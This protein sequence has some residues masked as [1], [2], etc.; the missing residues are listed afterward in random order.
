MKFE[1]G[2]DDITGAVN[3]AQKAVS[4]KSNVPQLEGIE[5]TAGFNSIVIFGSDNEIGVE[6]TFAALVEQTGAAVVNAR[7]FSDIVRN[8]QGDSVTVET[9]DNTK[10]RISS[11]GAVFNIF[12]IQTDTFPKFPVFEQTRM[13]EIDRLTLKRMFTQTS[14]AISTDETRKALTGLLLESA[15]GELRAVAVDGFRIALRKQ[16]V[17][18][19]G[20]WF[21]M[22][23]PARTVN[24]LI[25][26]IPSDMGD[27]RLYGGDNQAVI[28]FDG[29]RVY[30]RIIEGEFF[31][32][33]YILPNEH[34]TQIIVNKQ[35]LQD[36]IERA[37]LIISSELIK[38]YPVRINVA[39]GYISV[40]SRSD[41]GNAD[42]EIDVEMEGEPIELAFNPRFLIETL[43]AVEDEKIIMRFTT[44]VGQCVIKRINN[45][46]YTY[47]ILP[48]KVSE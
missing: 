22:I 29:T 23:I 35:L 44:R 33:R 41:V 15:N 24:E 30:T 28:E 21:K 19:E 32:Y 26:I 13:Y 25:K 5:I 47:L 40:Y 16:P 37:A 11:A 12:T 20:A 2:R 3:N 8:L 34:M 18:P 4:A 27:L 42:N 39:D 1:C 48:V 45:D 9:M 17:D 10:I 7:L 14:F 6:C 46:N 43:R 36:A 38:R 31:N